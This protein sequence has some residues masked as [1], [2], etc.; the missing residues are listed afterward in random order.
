[1]QIEY[2]QVY[3]RLSSRSFAG[4]LEYRGWTSILVSE[5]ALDGLE[6]CS[7]CP[8][9]EVYCSSSLDLP[10]S[11]VTGLKYEMII[12]LS[13]FLNKLNNQLQ[14]FLVSLCPSFVQKSGPF[15]WEQSI[16]FLS[17]ILHVILAIVLSVLRC[18]ASDYP[19]LLNT[20]GFWLPL[21]SEYTWLLLFDI[22]R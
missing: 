13:L 3:V 6:N 16:V 10:L 2:I 21:A 15:Y 17:H 20:T 19:R 1:M 14:C 5:C 8:K 22:V 18:S 11:G 12:Y 7:Y 4:V 9:V